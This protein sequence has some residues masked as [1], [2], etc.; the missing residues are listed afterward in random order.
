MAT[1]HLYVEF[2]I[3]TQTGELADVHA[4]KRSD[5]VAHRRAV[6]DQPR[7]KFNRQKHP[8]DKAGKKFKKAKE[9]PM[10]VAWGSPRCVIYK[11]SAGLIR[12]CW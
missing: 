3:D 8:K 2:V 12:L 10:V 11:T 5:R 1:K 9:H 4:I 6:I 7:R